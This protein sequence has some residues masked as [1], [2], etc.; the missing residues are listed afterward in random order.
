MLTSATVQGGQSP[1]RAM[2]RKAP[3]T[4]LVL[5][6]WLPNWPSE[7]GIMVPRASSRAPPDTSLRASWPE[8]TQG[9][10][11]GSGVTEAAPTP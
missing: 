2:A 7:K 9:N 3:P 4:R 5:P 6:P 10:R 8:S 1:R 11:P